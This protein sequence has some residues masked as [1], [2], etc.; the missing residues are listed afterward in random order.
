MISNEYAAGFFDGEGCVNL[1]VSGKNR[2]VTLRVMLVNTDE[3]ILAAFQAQFGGE[4]VT[5]RTQKNPT[6]KKFRMLK[7]TG[8]TAAAFLIDIAPHV[9]V[10]SAQIALALEF[11]RFKLRPRSE[12]CDYVTKKIGA[13]A[14]L[15]PEILHQEHA[16]K[17]QMH[18]LNAKGRTA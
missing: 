3:H 6:W 7:M 5:C 11:W 8:H 2:L 4:K 14:R 17:A 18:L 15:K 13:F 9:R 1:S 12:R 16:F 10:K